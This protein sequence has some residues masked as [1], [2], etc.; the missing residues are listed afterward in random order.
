VTGDVYDFMR[1]AHCS[2]EG[3]VGAERAQ[4]K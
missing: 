2:F 1:S 4:R 3:D